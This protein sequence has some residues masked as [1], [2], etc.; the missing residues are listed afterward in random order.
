M[1]QEKIEAAHRNI[2]NGKLA[3]VYGTVMEKYGMW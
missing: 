1:S 2:Y 3:Q